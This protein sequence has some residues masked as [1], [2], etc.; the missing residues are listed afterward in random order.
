MSRLFSLIYF[1]SRL[2]DAT[3]DEVV[4]CGDKSMILYIRD[5][6]HIKICTFYNIG[7]L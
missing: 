6:E 4:I 2:D 1:L 5:N 7:P 3:C